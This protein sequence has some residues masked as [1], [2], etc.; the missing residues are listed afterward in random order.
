MA[1]IVTG[2]PAEMLV[3]TQTAPPVPQLMP[4]TLLVT[5]PPVGAGVIV[6]AAAC[7][8]PVHATMKIAARASSRPTHDNP[9]S[10]GR[11][12]PQTIVLLSTIS[13]FA[14][15]FYLGG[16]YA[17]VTRGGAVL[18]RPAACDLRGC[19]SGSC[20]EIA[21]A[22][23]PM[24]CAGSTPGPRRRSAPAAVARWPR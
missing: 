23:A 13:P 5:V 8:R 18:R 21:R 1:V 24:R 16:R 12:Q 6:I 9:A 4:P 7:A 20:R 2:V 22:R 3:E 10:P 15:I 17:S 19:A 11:A 14:R